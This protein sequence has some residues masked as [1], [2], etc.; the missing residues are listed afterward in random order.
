[1]SRILII[2]D[3]KELVML[4]ADELKAKGHEVLSVYEGNEGVK[5][6]RR[7]PDLII[8]DI[9]IPGMNGFDV[10]RAIRDEV[11]CPIIF[12]SAKQ[13]EADRIRGL[14]LGGDDYVV[15][16]FGL[17]EFLARIDANLRR[18]K[19]AQYLNAESK[20]TKLFFGKLDMD[21]RS[22]VVRIDGVPIALTKREYDIVELLAMHGGQVFSRD[23]IY[24]KVWGYDAEGDS[25][26]VVEHVKKIRAKFTEADPSGEYILTVWGIGYKWNKA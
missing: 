2:D 20:R 21:L 22:R 16:P 24:G 12:L 26:T 7:Q 18:E 10:C 4:L 23:Q 11:L 15:K 25:T 5:L 8:L 19:R 13:S 9:M 3:E 6:A 14:T 17:Q 1:M